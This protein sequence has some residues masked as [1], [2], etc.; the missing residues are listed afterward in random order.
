MMMAASE[1]KGD[2]PYQVG[3]RAYNELAKMR[4]ALEQKV[5]NRRLYEDS[6]LKQRTDIQ[7]NPG[8]YMPDALQRLDTEYENPD[9]YQS[10]TIPRAI[11]GLW[12]WDGNVK[13]LAEQLQPTQESRSGPTGDG[14]SRYTDIKYVPDENIRE[15]AELKATDPGANNAALLRY[16]S[17]NDAGKQEIQDIAQRNNMSVAGAML[18]KDLKVKIGE[19]QV[20]SRYQQPSAF[21]GGQENQKIGA[22]WLIGVGRGIIGGQAGA[23]KGMD[24]AKATRWYDLPA[25]QRAEIRSAL[26][27]KE[28]WELKDYEVV[29]DYNNLVIDKAANEG[30]APY[31]I[32]GIIRNPRTMET[33]V[34]YATDPVVKVNSFGQPVETPGDVRSTGWIKPEHF[35]SDVV[36]PISNNNDEYDVNVVDKTAQEEFGINTGAGREIDMLRGTQWQRPKSGNA[37]GTQASKRTAGRLD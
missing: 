28:D 22:K 15:Q 24:A 27:V 17:L 5:A 31:K 32:R 6:Y 2:D 7:N 9:Y 25:N 29:K 11:P 16:E 21:A 3:S 35:Y 33:R 10:N 34:V 12:D 19:T 8:S 20:T 37:M 18:Y 30:E 36:R 13:R 1:G 4:T 14:G 26:G 23:E